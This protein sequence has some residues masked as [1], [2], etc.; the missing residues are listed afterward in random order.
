MPTNPFLD[1][2][3]THFT[4]EQIRQLGSVWV[5]IAGAGGLGSNVAAHL[6]RSGRQAAGGG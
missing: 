5:G 2:L 1:G 6:V 4:D 3:K